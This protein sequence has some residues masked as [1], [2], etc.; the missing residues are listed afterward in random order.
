MVHDSEH[1]V[2]D[3]STPR[4]CTRDSFRSVHRPRP[5]RLRWK[6]RP[7]DRAATAAHRAGRMRHSV[8]CYR[9]GFIHQY[10]PKY[11]RFNL[12]KIKCQWK[13]RHVNG[14]VILR[15]FRLQEA[16]VWRSSWRWLVWTVSKSDNPTG[17]W[18]LVQFIFFF[19]N[20]PISILLLGFL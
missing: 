16:S 11:K 14:Y 5:I 17:L 7:L 18:C 19:L 8:Y 2:A 13:Y 4:M 12:T 3:D 20:F 6:T 15:Y 1:D 9:Q 10:Q